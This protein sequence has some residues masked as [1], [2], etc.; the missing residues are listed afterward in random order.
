MIT[1]KPSSAYPDIPR[2][3]YMPE[4][5]EAEHA[6]RAAVQAVEDMPGHV[7]L[8]DAVVLLGQ[9][10]DKVADYVESSECP[11]LIGVI[12]VYIDGVYSHSLE[13]P[14][15]A[16]I[17]ASWLIDLVKELHWSSDPERAAHRVALFAP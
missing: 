11:Y 1:P 15:D 8:T 10:K 9:A 12:P 7:L 17:T 5:T 14:S 4:W 3:A 2:R 16:R 6:I 13:A